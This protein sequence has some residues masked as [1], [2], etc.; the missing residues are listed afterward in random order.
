MSVT[1][2]FDGLEELRQALRKLPETLA[3]EAAAIVVEH[4]QLAHDQI[5]NGYPQGPTGNLKHRVTITKQSSRVTTKATV[6]SRA[7]HAWIFE[8]GTHRRVTSHGAN[9]GRMPPAS[10]A[11]AMIPKVIRVRRQMMEALKDLVV[12][13]GFEVSQQ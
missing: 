4:A 1:L 12:R 13:A 9:R 7:P 10:D 8:H 2:R 3:T 6:S 5:Q 11:Q